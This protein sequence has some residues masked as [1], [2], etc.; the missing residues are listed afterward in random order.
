MST[1]LRRAMISLVLA[2]IVTLV[3]AWAAALWSPDVE[4]LSSPRNTWS[5]VTRADAAW[6]ADLPHLPA[7]VRQRTTELKVS[8]RVG[9]GVMRRSYAKVQDIPLLSGIPMIGRFFTNRGPP[10]AAVRWSVGWPAPALVASEVNEHYDM[11]D[12]PTSPRAMTIG[13]ALVPSDGLPGMQPGRV[14]PYAPLWPGLIVNVAV[15]AITIFIVLS[16]PGLVVAAGRAVRGHCVSCGYPA[17]RT[18]TCPECG[19]RRVD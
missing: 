7:S 16:A 11:D 13:A 3:I 4:V 9:P 10:R 18:G 19:A 2:P 1:S 6:L 14:L 8:V 5:P 17:P 15:F 12:A